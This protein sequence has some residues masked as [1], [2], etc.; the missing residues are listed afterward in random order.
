MSE[1]AEVYHYQKNSAPIAPKLKDWLEVFTRDVPRRVCP[2]CGCVNQWQPTIVVHAFGGVRVAH[3]IMVDMGAA[4]G[5][6]HKRIGTIV[7]WQG[8]VLIASS[9]ESKDEG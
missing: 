8:R 7:M 9:A 2:I 5:Y 1:Q 6:K 3:T 4:G